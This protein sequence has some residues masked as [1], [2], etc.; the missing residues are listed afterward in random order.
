MERIFTMKK[1]LL[2]EA[3]RIL[4]AL[5]LA[6]ALSLQAFAADSEVFANS[7]DE[8]KSQH[9]EYVNPLIEQPEDYSADFQAADFRNAPTFRVYNWNDLIKAF[10]DGMAN[11]YT[12]FNV[13]GPYYDLDSIFKEIYVHTGNPKQGD[14][15]RWN[16]SS[17]HMDSSGPADSRSYYVSVV[18]LCNTEQEKAVDAK[19][20]EV[21]AS[22]ELDGKNEY[23]KIRA[24]YDYI[25]TNVTYDFDN[26]E[27]ETYLLKHS[28]Y[29][30]L[31]NKT[32]VCQGYATLFY[33][34]CLEAGIDSRVI[35]G[36]AGE[37]H[38]WNIVKLGKYYYYVDSTW[39]AGM[40]YYGWFLI[41][42]ETFIRHIPDPEEEYTTA[43][44][45]EKYPMGP[46]NYVEGQG[47]VSYRIEDGGKTLVIYGTGPMAELGGNT[48]GWFDQRFNFTKLVVEEG[49]TTVSEQGLAHCSNAKTA[50]IADSVKSIGEDAFTGCS[51]L[52]TVKLGKGLTTISDWAFSG[53][54]SLKS[55]TIPIG[56]TQIGK[57]IFSNV[58]NITVCGGRGTAA[59]EYAAANKIK[60]V[61]IVDLDA[62][63][64]ETEADLVI[65]FDHI[66]GISSLSV[67][68]AKAADITGDGAVNIK[69]C[70][71]LYLLLNEQQSNY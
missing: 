22:L 63:G 42:G 31:I 58:S 39:D 12:T 14:Y 70:N 6:L 9:L 65:I 49:V 57:D 40:E 4:L 30:A 33:R 29:A 53:C 15:L 61:P 27:D 50:E 41:G 62:D 44:F 8:P 25:C 34:M 13:V 45:K 64:E 18:Y 28:T 68:Y 24:I 2:R 23:Q 48:P 52:E 16:T 17:L 69:D 43:A 19:I 10:R 11:R 47:D 36:M 51:S 56:V 1:H 35:V 54:R 38:A 67:Q 32:A 5:A 3:L 46:N 66:K 7:D 55:I 59:Q 21:M 20:P 60:F 26:L 37:S 71:S